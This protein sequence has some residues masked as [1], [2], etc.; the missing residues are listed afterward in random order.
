MSVWYQPTGL[1][2]LTEQTVN[3][4]TRSAESI[5]EEKFYSPE[6]QALFLLRSILLL[7]GSGSPKCLLLLSRVV[8]LSVPW[9]LGS[10]FVCVRE[11]GGDKQKDRETICVCVCV[12]VS[13]CVCG[14]GR[15]TAFI[16]G[17]F[18]WF[19]QSSTEWEATACCVCTQRSS[20]VLKGTIELFT[21]SQRAQTTSPLP[22][23]MLTD[24]HTL[25]THTHTDPSLRLSQCVSPLSNTK[26]G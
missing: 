19:Q 8:R 16:R 3:V 7:P 13:V 26:V 5:T 18:E 22:W 2:L 20:F 23:R 14:L 4:L 10:P 1:S 17:L 9:E 11:W 15:V 25:H 6:W 21:E 12:C 24:T